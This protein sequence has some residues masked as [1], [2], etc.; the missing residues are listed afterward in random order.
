MQRDRLGNY[1][2]SAGRAKAMDC[3]RE[4]MTSPVHP[5]DADVLLGLVFMLSPLGTALVRPPKG[6]ASTGP[7]TGDRRYV[8]DEP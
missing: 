5:S 1:G 3:A 4:D 7:T 6:K 2:D 8:A